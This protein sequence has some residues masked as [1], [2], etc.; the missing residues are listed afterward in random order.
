MSTYTISVRIIHDSM[1]AG[2]ISEGLR[3]KS[4]WQ[5]SKGDRKTSPNG[6]PLSGLRKDSFWVGESIAGS[7]SPDNDIQRMLSELSENSEFVEKLVGS[8]GRVEILVG[9]F[10]SGNASL[11]LSNPIVKLADRLNVDIRIELYPGD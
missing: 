8:G 10:L 4:T 7:D 1:S 9:W 6:R 3:M 11:M 2:E 5:Y